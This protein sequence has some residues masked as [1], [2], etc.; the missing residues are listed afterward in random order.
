VTPAEKVAPIVAAF[1]AIVPLILLWSG[2][3][4]T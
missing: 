4:E 1:L 3:R 2:R